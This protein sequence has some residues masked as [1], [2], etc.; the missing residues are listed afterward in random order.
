M[1]RNLGTHNT[2]NSGRF[3]CRMILLQVLSCCLIVSEKSAAQTDSAQAAAASIRHDPTFTLKGYV[4]FLEQVS[5]SPNPAEALTNELLHNRLNFLYRPS[6][7]FKYRLEIRNRI[8]YGQLVQEYPGYSA[9]VAAPQGTFDLS[10]NWINQNGI[11][12]NST[13]D[14]ASAEYTDD[15][16]DITLG[17]QRINW[18]IN[19][20]WTPNDIFNT[21]NY[22]DFDYEERPGSDAARVQYAF[23]SSSSLDLAISPGLTKTMDVGALMYHFNRWNYDFQMFSGIYHQDYVAGAGWA[24]NIFNA[25]FKAELS[26]FTPYQEATD[27]GTW[28]ASVSFDYGFKNGIYL[29]VSGL[30]NGRG[31]DS[32][33]NIAKLTTETLSAENIFPFR[34]TLFAEITYSFSPIWKGSLAGM[35]SPAGNAVIILPTLT[36][37]V[38][39]NWALDFI[40]QSFYSE[41][42]H[43]YGAL[44]SGVYLRLKWGF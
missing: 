33:P 32:I 8:Y 38:A 36:W 40:A 11:L 29:L 17:R 3:N 21:F 23:N 10:K 44:G 2:I 14:R 30:Y 22:F 34:Y 42:G 35:Y 41:T 7:H 13:I 31:T 18:G 9:L 26:Y 28:T 15:K 5:Y 1:H 39:N 19:T 43:T 20:V 37:S 24:G 27:S 4:K 16:W 12:A 6:D 25:G